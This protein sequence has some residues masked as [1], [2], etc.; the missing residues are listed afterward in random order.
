MD[1]IFETKLLKYKKH[2][3]QVL[4]ICSVRDTSISMV[5]HRLILLTMQRE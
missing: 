5:R 1:G 4:R 3:I 2:I